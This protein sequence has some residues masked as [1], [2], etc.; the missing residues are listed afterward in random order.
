MAGEQ[1]RVSEGMERGALLSVDTD[2]L[3]GRQA[4]QDAGRLGGD[5]KI[6]RRHARISRGPDQ[7]L[8]IEDL[9]SANGTFV[10]DERIEGPRLLQVGDLIRVGGTVLQV[11]AGSGAAPRAPSTPAPRAPSTPQQAPRARE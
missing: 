5:F 11:T 6:S 9:G 4:P 2:L 10:N 8:T 3:L 7:R 1:L